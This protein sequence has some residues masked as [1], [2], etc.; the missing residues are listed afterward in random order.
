MKLVNTKNE[1]NS[2]DKIINL[3]KVFV[4]NQFFYKKSF[5]FNKNIFCEKYLFFTACRKV[6]DFCL[7]NM[8]KKILIFLIYFK[9]WNGIEHYS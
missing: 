5:Y 8:I 9:W 4:S 2:D 6:C 7:Y 1:R 3:E